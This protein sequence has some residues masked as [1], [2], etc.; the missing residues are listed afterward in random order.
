[1]ISFQNLTYSYQESGDPKSLDAINLNIKDGECILLCGKSGCGKTT[2]T[3]LLNGMIPNFYDGK[4]Q[5]LFFWTVKTFPTCL[6]TKFPKRW[7]A[8]FKIPGHSFT[9]SIPPVKLL[10]GVRI[11]AWSRM[12]LRPV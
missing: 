10:L 1:M 7:E 4:L 2:M 3:R 9:Q 5:G 12:K 11:S 6:C 8:C